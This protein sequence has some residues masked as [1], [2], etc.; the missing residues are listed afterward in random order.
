MTSSPTPEQIK[1][2][3][4]NGPAARPPPGVEPNFVDP[5]NLDTAVITVLSVCLTITSFAVLI[6]LYTKLFVM[7]S[8]AYEDCKY[9][10]FRS[11]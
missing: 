5:T 4:L 7:K 11:N 6:R 3:L 10:L 1:A 2:A 9:R 8:A